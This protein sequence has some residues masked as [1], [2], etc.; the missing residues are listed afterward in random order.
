M[1]NSS[2]LKLSLITASIA[3]CSLF[4]SCKSD[5][6]STA[7]SS[8]TVA[9]ATAGSTLP[10]AEGITKE[11]V[12]RIVNECTG[13]DVVFRDKPFSMNQHE[14]AAIINDLSFI[15]PESLSEIP[16]GCTPIA[17]KVYTTPQDVIIE[18]DVYYAENCYLFVFI[19]NEK[20][21]F[22]N[23]MN[24]KGAEFYQ[25]LFMQVSQMQN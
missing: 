13:I 23:K 1:A 25:K 19:E 2:I 21:L 15:S 14:K 20:P 16:S 5:S 11:V 10:S 7:A 9:T 6:T 17:R 12:D 4:F 24:Q 18:A 22:A 8:S 3:F